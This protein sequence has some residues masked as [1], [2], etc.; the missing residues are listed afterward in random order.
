MSPETFLARVEELLGELG[1]PLAMTLGHAPA[2]HGRGKRVRPRLIHACAEAVGLSCEWAALWAALVETVHLA[3]LLHDDVIDEAERRRG[4]PSLRKQEGNRRAIL[5]GDLLISAVWLESARYLPPEV[6]T[7]LARALLAMSEAEL[8]ESELLWN[9]DATTS[10]Y[11]SVVDGK[12]A[13]LFAAATEGT[14]AL[15]GAPSAIRQTFGRSGLALG[16]AFQ[17]EDD[18]SD[19]LWGPHDS[20]K[21][22]ERDL[23]QG[24]VTLPLIFALKREGRGSPT[25]RYLCSRGHER[26]DH[27]ALWRLLVESHAIERSRR[28]ARGFL[29][30]GLRELPGVRVPE[31]HTPAGS[32]SAWRS[33]Q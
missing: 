2:E 32:M 13:A 12:T 27:R 18:I 28:L 19:Y 25:R 1:R 21:D 3:S 11:L 4:Q 24:L 5:S 8:R 10:L 29:R 30:H 14:A 9:P 22:A 20:G 33:R 7:I 17:I 23:D 6:T 26:L 15:A 16:R 31:W